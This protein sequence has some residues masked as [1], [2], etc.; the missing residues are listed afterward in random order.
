[1]TVAEDY[2]ALRSEVGARRLT[3]DVVLASGADAQEFLHGQLSQDLA[4]LEVGRSVWSLLLQP[5]GKLV[6]HLRVS[7]LDE[8]RYALD[9]ESGH[10][11]SVQ[12][13][14]E[15]FKLRVDCELEVVSWPCVALRG[16]RAG[17]LDLA[18]PEG[19]VVADADWVG[20]DGVDLL[21]P[22][23]SVP[24]GVREVGPEAFAAVAIE[25]GVPSMGAELDEETI[26]AA[27]GIVDHAVSFTKGCYTGQE[28][29]ARIDAR[30][31]NTPTHLRGLVIETEELPTIG[32]PVV[33]DGEEVGRLT[34]V[35]R[36]PTLGVVAL[37]HVSRRVEPPALASVSGRR[38]S[39]RELPLL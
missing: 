24:E 4:A 12:A 29:V 21:G 36:S 7:R 8:N 27:V 34:T 17:A 11:S 20:V 39:V 19:G 22:A 28:L 15:R 18:V 35:G 30:G 33:I 3:R 5:Q 37:A 32:S 14:L 9:V 16:P 13:R 38:A 10:G 2:Q 6:A 25:A 1:M 31:S 23:V 26:P